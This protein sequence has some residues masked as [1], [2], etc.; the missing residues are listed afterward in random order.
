VDYQVADVLDPPA[1]WREAFDLVV[2]SLTVQALPDPPRRDAIARIGQMVAP[3][4][5]LVVIA[6]ARDAGEEPGPWPPWPITRAEVE[7]FAEA[8]LVPV[9]IDEV[10]DPGNQPVARRWLAEFRRPAAEPGD[11]RPP[12]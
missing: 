7:A 1:G 5:S 10:A 8:G 3:G 12:G 2:E 9:R 4:G 11:C 6:L